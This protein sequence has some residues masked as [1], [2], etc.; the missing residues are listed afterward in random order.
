MQ[1]HGMLQVAGG[2]SRTVQEGNPAEDGIAVH[3]QR[4]AEVII[5]LYRLYFKET[6]TYRRGQ[7][8]N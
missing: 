1:L 7:R 8:G 5:V 6:G 3:E 4:S 2:K